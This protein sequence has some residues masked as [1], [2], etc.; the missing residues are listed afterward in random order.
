MVI[1]IFG[2]WMLSMVIIFSGFSSAQNKF[3]LL[4][5]D[6]TGLVMNPPSCKMGGKDILYYP[7]SSKFLWGIGISLAMAAKDPITGKRVIL[8]DKNFIKQ[9]PPAFQQF[10][11]SHE[12][13]HHK[14][15]HVE[16]Y[17]AMSRTDGLFHKEYEEEADCKAIKRLRDTGQFGEQE[18]KDIYNTI[19]DDFFMWKTEIGIKH[20]QI[21]NNVPH[22]SNE[23]RKEHVMACV[24]DKYSYGQE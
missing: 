9:S 12:C 21:L 3:R 16:I 22:W 20:T 17:A 14:N 7:V 15:G 2:I 8:F 10:V 6:Q 1:R 18:F 5:V 11:F 13:E 4:S 19:T 23:E 24:H